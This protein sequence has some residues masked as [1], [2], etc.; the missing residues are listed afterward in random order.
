MGNAILYHMQAGIPGDITRA[1]F[2]KVEANMIDP[3]YPPLLFGIPIKLVSGLVRPVAG[4][5]TT[6][7]IY[8]LL[9]R[10][11]PYNGVAGAGAALGAGIP[12]ASGPCDVMRSGHMAVKLARGTAVKGA[13]VYVRITA[14]V[15]AV[16]DIEDTA[17]SGKCIA[18]GTF[19]GPVDALRSDSIVEIAFKV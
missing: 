3:A 4:G 15:G 16:G 7:D 1:E 19:M 13:S 10:P 18:F 14:G 2:S 12:P 17:D 11:Y 9:V 6:A 5:E 8:G